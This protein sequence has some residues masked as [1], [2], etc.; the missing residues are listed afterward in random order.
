VSVARRSV[1]LRL[2]KLLMGL[3]HDDDRRVHQLAD[4][5]RDAAERHDVRRDPQRAERD[6]RHEHGYREGDERD[7]SARRVPQKEQHDED[8]GEYHLDECLPLSIAPRISADR[9]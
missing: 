9:S 2:L 7:E 6:E 3:F 5:E 4:R 1:A 8:H